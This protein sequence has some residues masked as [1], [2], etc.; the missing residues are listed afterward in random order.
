MSGPRRSGTTAAARARAAMSPWAALL[1]LAGCLEPPAEST[2]AGTLDTSGSFLGDGL[3]DEDV[4]L[5]CVTPDQT[6]AEPLLDPGSHDAADRASFQVELPREQPTYCYFV[7]RTDPVD[8]FVGMLGIDPATCEGGAGRERAW[9]VGD[10]RNLYAGDVA[11]GGLRACPA[12]DISLPAPADAGQPAACAYCGAVIIDLSTHPDH[13]PEDTEVFPVCVALEPDGE[14][15]RVEV[16]LYHFLDGQG[17]IGDFW[18]VLGEATTRWE[19]VEGGLALSALSTD[20]G[21]DEG[22]ALVAMLHVVEEGGGLFGA[23]EGLVANTVGYGESDW[24][25]RTL[26]PLEPTGD[27]QVPASLDEL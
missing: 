13:D 18:T 12:E 25:A 21:N 19:H 20:L 5:V 8:R 7:Q 22:V 14:N 23:V 4:D 24:V 15:L 27:C 6:L 3:A 2:L 16:V 26:T 10:G 11:A 17:D 1:A 9:I